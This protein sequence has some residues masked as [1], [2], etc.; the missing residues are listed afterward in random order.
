M[1][2][3]PDFFIAGAPKAGTSAL[4]AA[5]THHPQLRLS[6]PKEP[7]LFLRDGTPGSGR[8]SFQAR[9]TRSAR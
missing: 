3:W 5:L 7:K 4:H 9:V 2:R 8:G 6:R 1:A